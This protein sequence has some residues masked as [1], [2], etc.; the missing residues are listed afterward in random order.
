MPTIADSARAG[1]AGTWVGAQAPGP[2]QT[3]PF[4]QL[5][6]NEARA[7]DGRDEYYAF[8]S[9]TAQHFH[10]RHIFRVS[11]GDR[12]AAAMQLRGGRWTLSIKDV[13]S[14]ADRRVTTRQEASGAFDEAQWIQEDVTDARTGRPFG[15]PTMSPLHFS[16]V[17]ADGRLVDAASLLS[18]WMKLPAGR[19][20]APTPVTGGAFTMRSI[21]LSGTARR[22][23]RLID[24]IDQ[25]VGTF[26]TD[27]ET[28]AAPGP[29]A[30]SRLQSAS[31]Q[32]LAEIQEQ[33]PLLVPSH[34]PGSIRPD[35]TR[36]ILEIDRLTSVLDE[37]ALSD[38][39]AGAPPVRA[40]E[41]DVGAHLTALAATSHAI[42]RILGAPDLS[43]ALLPPAE[44][45][46]QGASPS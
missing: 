34:W 44:L 4:I 39:Q 5:G 32:F 23:L 41:A 30:R 29:P 7:R 31:E 1:L 40:W 26:E 14:G 17:T 13:S 46:L 42:R 27:T 33:T 16:G 15:Y 12:I 45:A 35:I 22:Y 25:A 21:R 18:Q 11:P 20:L 37:R 24:P 6:V 36:M 8:W 19:S 3:S 9:D 38:E 10:P 2:W 28:A 43:Q